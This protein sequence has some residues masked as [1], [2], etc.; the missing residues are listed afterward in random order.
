MSKYK[1]YSQE[2]I[3]EHLS[4]FLLN[5]WSYSKL[6]Q[7]A[8]NEK[9]FEMRY[10]YGVKG[11]VS[12]S[13]MAGSAF[14]YAL[15]QYFTTLSTDGVE[16]GIE[17]LEEYVMQ[18]I[19]TINPINI[20]LQKTTPTVEESKSKAIQ[21]A[22]KGIRFFYAEREL[23][24]SEIAQILDVEINAESWL[25]V[26]G[27]DIPL[28]CRYQI[29]L[30]VLTKSGKVVVIDHKLKAAYSDEITVTL[31]NCIQAVT[32]A[33]GYKDLEDGINVDEVWF[34]ETKPS[35]NKDKS[36]QVRK[37]ILSMDDDSIR[38]Y[39]AQL[40][41]PL[42]RM[43]QAVQDMDYTYVYNPSDA[44]VDK[45]EL[46]EFWAK[47]LIAEV[48]DFNV[49]PMKRDM[50]AQRLRKIRDTNSIMINPKVITAFREN[51]SRFI[52]YDLSNT[53]MTSEQKIEH[54]LA[55]FG[56]IVKVAHRLD[57]YSSY[58][59]LLE[60]SAG[61]KIGSVQSRHLE[62]ANALN[63]DKVRIGGKLT[64]YNG[65]SYVSVEV[66]QQATTR[67]DFDS[68]LVKPN[69]LPLGRDN[70]GNTVYWDL[71]NHSTP[72]MLI[73]GATGSGK[74]IQIKTIIAGARQA[75]YD[76]VIIFDPKYEFLAYKVR[77]F[78]VYNE[79][80]EIEEE[81]SRLVGEM[82][83][84]VKEGKVS[85]TLVIFDEFADAIANSRKGKDLEVRELVEVGVYANGRPKTQV[86]KT[87]ELKSLEENLRV[88]AQKG[89]SAG[90]RIVTATQRASTKVITGD[91]KVN[92]PVQICFRVPKETDSRV[93]LDEGGAETLMGYGDGLI[94]SPSYPDTLRFQA[95][96]TE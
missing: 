11:K 38:L 3:D 41:E 25:T 21:T 59:Y 93:V 40:Y 46:H 43:I 36:P 15:E 23:I 95:F 33:L 39:Q 90:Y 30:V 2:Q 50:V 89:R 91:A 86:R 81:M 17:Q 56:I 80:I 96:Y 61:T 54:I 73:C 84:T 42:K 12:A 26:N 44:Y 49:L 72:H 16:L 92:F 67:L 10:I 69:M 60:V 64:V 18:Y 55:T 75:G 48:D 37:H 4:G 52:Q 28:P 7:F 77:G 66:S 70:F 8:R 14:H 94:K 1:K 5:S 78:E 19:S 6:A 34:V 51:A 45:A 82:Q 29:D 71:A 74:S 87:G 53:N 31:D 83:Q 13:S 63:V 22:I 32:Y 68:T 65:K 58:T 85:K 76:R 47:T 24:T 79:I 9:A 20:K 27:V 35:E 88:L 57:G 62:I